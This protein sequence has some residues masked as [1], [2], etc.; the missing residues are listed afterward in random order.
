[1]LNLYDKLV[2]DAAG[3]GGTTEAARVFKHI[4]VLKEDNAPVVIVFRTIPNDPNF[5]LVVGPKFL[6]DNSRDALMRAVESKDGQSS[7]ELGTHI[8]RLNFQDGVNMLA[9]L[10][11]DNYLKKFETK[12]I[13]V[14]YGAGDA[15]KISLDK[16]NQMIADDMKVSINELAVK[17]NIVLAKKEKSNKKSNAKEAAK[18]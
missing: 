13:I 7:F 15:G 4:G 8:A 11:V 1:M 10:H 2:M 16:L 9:S 3:T 18:N 12:D 6:P 17:E 5:C 14:T